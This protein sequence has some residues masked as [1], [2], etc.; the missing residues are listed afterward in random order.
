MFGVATSARAAAA[1]RDATRMAATTTATLLGQLDRGEVR[2]RPGDVVIADEFGMQGTRD[3]SRRITATQAVGARLV[4]I[5]DPKQ[6]PE[7]EAGGLLGALMKRLPV[8]TLDVNRRQHNLEE[9][10][11][12]DELRAGKTDAAVR[13]YERNGNLTLA[14]DPAELCDQLVTD[15]F[16]A[17]EDVDAAHRRHPSETGL[18][19]AATR[20]GTHDLNA[21][22]RELLFEHGLLGR[23]LAAIGSLEFAVGD[24]VVALQN[25]YDLGVLNGDFGTVVGA[26]TTSVRIRLDSGPTRVVPASY[27]VDGHLDHGYAT[28][29]HK[30]QGATCERLFL[31]GDEA[32]YAELGYTALSRGREH[33]HVY[34][35]R[36]DLDDAGDENADPL[37]RLARRLSASHA[38]TAA[39][40]LDPRDPT[41]TDESPR[42]PRKAALLA[43]G[44]ASRSLQSD[45]YRQPLDQSL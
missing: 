5:G 1:M 16:H 10:L 24:R 6:L 43:T 7:I 22:A 14:D 29:V 8:V 39:V 25:R 27:V 34:A 45:Q 19:V 12:L 20:H 30:G 26:D 37:D 11:A 41:N 38:Q 36:A 13:R 21:R 4:I 15:W 32:V 42:V 2:L 3:G 44:S 17:G 9:R 23:P 35:L 31:L 28:T 18:M 40:D 33:N